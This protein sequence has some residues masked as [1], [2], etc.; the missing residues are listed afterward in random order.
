MQDSKSES[1]IAFEHV[2]TMHIDGY[3]QEV[4]F[5]DSRYLK[6]LQIIWDLYYENCLFPIKNDFISEDKLLKT[7]SLKSSKILITVDK[8]W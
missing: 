2:L 8:V 5:I 4:H 7:Q 1:K 6:S 3:T